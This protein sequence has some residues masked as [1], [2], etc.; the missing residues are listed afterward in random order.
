MKTR[1]GSAW[2]AIAG[3]CLGVRSAQ[4]QA[5]SRVIPINSVATSLPASTTQDVTIQLWDAPS[6]GTL[7]FA[8]A[9]PGLPVDD[10][11]A[12]SV[13]FGGQTATGLD[14]TNFPTG[15]S[16]FLDVVDGTS[17]SVLAGRIPLAAVAFALSP[18]P[19]GPPGPPGPR[20]DTGPQGN[21]GQQGNP[22]PPGPPGSQGPP[23][24]VQAVTAGD[25]SVSVAGTAANPSVSVAP[26]G[27]TAPKISLP[28]SLSGSTIG[29]FPPPILATSNNGAGNGLSST[30][31]SGDAVNGVSTNG[32]GVVGIHTATTGTAPAVFGQTFSTDVGAYGVLGMSPAGGL[33]IGVYGIGFVGVRGDTT[34]NGGG[35][36][37]SGIDNGTGNNLAGYFQG[38]V[39]ITGPLL[40]GTVVT[41]PGQPLCLNS[42]RQVAFCSSSS[43][44][45]KEQVAPFNS[46][47][48][49]VR[50]L[51]P[52]TFQWKESGERDLGLIAEE[53]DH[54]EPLLA[55]HSAQGV[56]EGVKYDRLAAVLIDAVQQQQAQI[57]RQRTM[58]EREHT[59]I[60]G[61]QRVACVEHPQAEVCR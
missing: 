14:P 49:L 24:V 48:D 53:V 37:V 36:A 52:V 15:S 50:R 11:G 7:L 27:I 39:Q 41:G 18:G 19:A 23:G 4:A 21:P 33:T 29:I 30:A 58:L 16:R 3:L 9:Q 25:A 57:E 17:T 55:F 54:V 46:G 47:L 20:G 12:I 51:R 35:V 61:L 1:L 44:R 42:T 22:G 56:T 60:Q 31:T 32:R 6:G 38:Q 45:Y 59:L 34:A 43:L 40:L 26:N 5:T 28:L 13:V 8:E 2:L 10:S